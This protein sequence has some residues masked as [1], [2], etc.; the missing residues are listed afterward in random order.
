MGCGLQ[1]PQQPVFKGIRGQRCVCVGAGGGE[2][3]RQ[4]TGSRGQGRWR[5]PE[6]RAGHRMAVVTCEQ[7]VATVQVPLLCHRQ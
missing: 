7:H 4:C 2:G 6:I 1:R 3:I 5:W